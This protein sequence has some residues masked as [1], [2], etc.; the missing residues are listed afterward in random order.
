MKKLLTATISCFAF[1]LL[2]VLSCYALE[3]DAGVQQGVLKSQEGRHRPVTVGVSGLW[4]RLDQ[5]VYNGL[6]AEAAGEGWYFDEPYPDADDKTCSPFMGLDGGT[7]L[8]YEFPVQA[9]LYQFRV[10]P[11]IGAH[12]NYMRQD[13]CPENGFKDARLQYLS[14]K[15]GLGVKFPLD[16]S[17]NKYFFVQGGAVAPLKSWS[18]PEG[19]IGDAWAEVEAGYAGKRFWISVSADH[20]AFNEPQTDLRFAWLKLGCRFRLPF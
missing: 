9:S 20:Q 13:R 4:L 12:Y 2:A 10:Y 8:R 7:K 16:E 15:L 19:S 3:L 6:F 17:G 11:Y 18:G 5:G 1:V 14:G